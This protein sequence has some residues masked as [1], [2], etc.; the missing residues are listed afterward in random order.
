MSFPDTWVEKMN[1][2]L[3]Q[4]WHGEDEPKNE[5]NTI[6]FLEFF[7]WFPTAT[8]NP[9]EVLTRNAWN[10]ASG[11]KLTPESIKAMVSADETENDSLRQ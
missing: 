6:R 4:A 10:D 3:A 7:R 9:I 8:P 2:E 1:E 5:P 11:E